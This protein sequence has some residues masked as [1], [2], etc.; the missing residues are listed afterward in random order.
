MADATSSFTTV[1]TTAEFDS[2][3]AAQGD[4]KPV[5]AVFFAEEVPETGKSW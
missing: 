1:A 3:L 2:T 5:Y 4:S